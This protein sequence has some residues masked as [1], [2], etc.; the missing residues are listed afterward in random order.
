[1]YTMKELSSLYRI[2]SRSLR[3]ALLRTGVFTEND[4]KKMGRRYPLGYEQLKPFFKVYGDLTDFQ[5]R[6]SQPAPPLQLSLF[7]QK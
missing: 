2:G 1:M 7:Q 4:L 6:V 5:A 3:K